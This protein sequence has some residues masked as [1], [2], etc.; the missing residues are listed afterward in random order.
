MT[1]F[2][3]MITKRRL[4]IIFFILL[5]SLSVFLYSQ[6]KICKLSSRKAFVEN[7][8][9]AEGKK[10]LNLLR[11]RKDA[12]ALGIFERL[13][14]ENPGNTAA[15][16]GKAEVLRRSRN[17]E[18]SEKILKCLLNNNPSHAPS[19]ISL[20]YI[21]LKQG[22]LNE[23]L[24]LVNRSL[25]CVNE[26]ADEKALAQL[27]LG[28]INSRRASKGIFLSKLAYGGRIKNHFLE[29]KRLAPDLPEVAVGLGTFYLLAPKIIGG[30]VGKAIPEL[31]RAVKMAP[32]FATAN[33]RLAQAYQK[34]GDMEKFN[35]YIA[36]AKAL[37]PEN[38]VLE[39]LK[40]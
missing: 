8:L 10:A 24:G 23:A 15:L 29:A 21:R 35:F 40:E 26:S 16:W 18:G 20:A 3:V 28:S 12:A 31:Q 5:A 36:R 33:A 4:L 7:S 34:I 13:L 6:K 38:E 2:K 39:E 27:M 1:P 11:L 25:F 14:V 9:T 22:N 30:D 32:E 19:L 17:Y 37:D